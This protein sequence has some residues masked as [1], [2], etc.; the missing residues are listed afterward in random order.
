MRGR[1]KSRGK[2]FG[3]DFLFSPSNLV[4]SLGSNSAKEGRKKERN[5]KEG[6]KIVDRKERGERSDRKCRDIIFSWHGK[7]SFY[8]SLLSERRQKEESKREREKMRKEEKKKERR[9][10]REKDFDGD[11]EENQL[12]RMD[13]KSLLPFFLIFSFFLALSLH[14]FVLIIW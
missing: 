2:V 8:F 11:Q 4:A 5:M 7:L 3:N 14:F 1:K 9:K 6:E 13:E 12:Q 10:E